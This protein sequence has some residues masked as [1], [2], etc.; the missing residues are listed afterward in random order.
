MVEATNDD[1][2]RR[3]LE[4]VGEK[5]PT[6]YLFG[7]TGTG[8]SSLISTLQTAAKASTTALI[9]GVALTKDPASMSVR[10]FDVEVTYNSKTKPVAHMVDTRGWNDG[11]TAEEMYSEICQLVTGGEERFLWRTEKRIASPLKR[12]VAK[13]HANANSI[14]IVGSPLLS[15]NQLTQYRS[16]KDM[17]ERADLGYITGWVLTGPREKGKPDDHFRGSVAPL[18]DRFAKLSN[19]VPRGYGEDVPTDEAIDHQALLLLERIVRRW[20]DPELEVRNPA[21]ALWETAVQNF[22]VDKVT[23]ALWSTFSPGNLVNLLV[24]FVVIWIVKSS[25]ASEILRKSR[26]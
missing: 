1:L 18:H 26:I 6:V 22:P 17:L 19:Y 24:L 12:R 9:G 15:D 5:V 7:F 11:T 8:K 23:K 2:R 10:S 3:V 25:S 4:A 20:S 14:L 13:T 16:L 21:L